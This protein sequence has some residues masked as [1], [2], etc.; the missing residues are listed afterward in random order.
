MREGQTFAQWL[1]HAQKILDGYG[2][3]VSIYKGGQ[4]WPPWYADLVFRNATQA[5]LAGGRYAQM[6]SP[7]GIEEAP[8]VMYRA[9]H[10]QRTRPTHAALDGMVFRKTDSVA[11][12][13]MPPWE[14]NCRCFVRSMALDELEEGGYQLMDG[15]QISSLPLKDG[16]IVGTPPPGWDRDQVEALVP[17]VMREPGASGVRNLPPGAPSVPGDSGLQRPGDA[18]GVPPSPE[19]R[20]SSP[21]S[22]IVRQAEKTA[23]AAPDPATARREIHDLLTLPEEERGSI[24]V[25]AAATSIEKRRIIL[26]VASDIEKMT[27]ARIPDIKVV[28]DPWFGMGEGE[29]TGI[30]SEIKVSPWIVDWKKERTAFAHELGHAVETVGLLGLVAEFFWKRAEGRVPVPLSSIPGMEWTALDPRAAGAMAIPGITPI[31]A[32]AGRIYPSGRTELFPVALEWL[33]AD[34]LHILMLDPELFEVMVGWL[35]RRP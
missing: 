16:G 7:E 35:R 6:F 31:D 18:A 8:F 13:Y 3:T 27:S 34:P 15:A 2:G 29:H 1:P 33:Y 17:G 5:A 14:H 21:K 9:L 12:R 23:E 22:E 24:P 10:D 19:P 26:P 20:P 11:R 28:V 25:D 4:T 32:Y 30:I